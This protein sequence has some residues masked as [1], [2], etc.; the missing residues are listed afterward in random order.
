MALDP[1]KNFAKVTV[2]TGYDSTAT[3]ITLN[4][5]DGDKLPDP[6][7]DGAFNLVW[8]N[9]TDYADPSDD[10]NVEIV[11]VTAKSGDTLTITRGQEGTSAAD[12]N[13][14]GKT[15]KMVLAITKKMVDDIESNKADKV[16]GA[17]ADNFASLDANGNLQD[18]GYNNSSFAPA[19]HTHTKSDITDTPWAWTDVDKTG[20]SINDIADVSITSPSA[21]HYLRYDGTNW[22]NSSIQAADLPSHTH[23]KSDI[24]DTPWAWSDVDKA[25][26][27]INDIADVSITTPSAGHYLRYDGTNWVNSSIQAGDLPS[28][29]H[30]ASDITSGQLGAAYGGTGLDTSASTGIPKISSGTWSVGANITDLGDVS[31]S[32]PSDGQVLTYN[33]STGKWENKDVGGGAW[34]LVESGDLTADKEISGLDG[35]THKFYKLIIKTVNTAS[36]VPIRLRFNGDSGSNYAVDYFR[37]YVSGGSTSTTHS[38]VTGISS[39]YLDAGE[40]YYQ[41]WVEALIM[42]ESGVPRKVIAHTF[43]YTDQNTLQN[44]LTA[45]WWTNTTSNITSI[46]IYTEG[47]TPDSGAKYWL[48]RP[49]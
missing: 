46:T 30:A 47:L 20:S 24:T 36:N 1:V 16:S 27:S 48:F 43:G 14:S 28:H 17:T 11:R 44:V 4:S 18:S 10:P 33:S 40:N 39:L 35:D 12:H 15:Y 31:I 23:T 21:G 6:A 41:S 34:V 8:W 45:G 2:S 3:S 25:G 19:S 22:V 38:R 7:T 5:G 29:S 32:S 37:A 42:A 13:L 49:A 26:S 9:A